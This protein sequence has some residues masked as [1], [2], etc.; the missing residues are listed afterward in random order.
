[1][2]SY[3]YLL[4]PKIAELV[5]RELPQNSVV[6]F[7]EAHNIGFCFGVQMANCSLCLTDNVCIESMSVNIKRR[8]IDACQG[9]IASL[10]AK[11]AEF[12]LRKS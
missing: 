8:D 10:K 12:V 9:N 6:V 11:V 7:D 2:Y 3:H 1:M 5:S 4:D